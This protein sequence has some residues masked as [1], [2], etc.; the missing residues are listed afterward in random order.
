MNDRMIFMY[1]FF[2]FEE[3]I[4]YRAFLAG[5]DNVQ[6]EVSYRKSV[7]YFR[8]Y[9]NALAYAGTRLLYYPSNPGSVRD[10]DCSIN[11]DHNVEELFYKIK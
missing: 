5:V 11:F 6:S 4:F 1:K 2:L 8:A 3:K 9:E 10:H 7:Y